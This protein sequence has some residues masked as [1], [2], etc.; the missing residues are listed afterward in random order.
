MRPS[1]TRLV[2]VAA[3]SFLSASTAFAECKRFGFTVNDYGKDGPTKDAKDLLDKHIAGKMA[4]RGVTTYQTGK[5]DVKCELFLDFIVFDEHTCTAEATVCWGGTALPKNQQVA[6]PEAG[7][8][9]PAKT[10]TTGSIEKK[11]K[12]AASV[13]SNPAASEPMIEGG[14][15][16]E[17]PRAAQ[18][19]AQ[20]PAPAAVPEA[21]VEAPAAA[22]PEPATESAAPAESAAPEATAAPTESE[23]ATP[24]P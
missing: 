20:A 9:K 4:E 6:S 10:T 15:T 14:R 24:S 8:A 2:T 19:P 21:P 7:A 22:T 18:A 5:K 12:S 17:Q 16:P 11:A 13:E 3:I 1:L 23:S